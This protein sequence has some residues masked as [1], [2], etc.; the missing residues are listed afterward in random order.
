MNGKVTES[1]IITGMSIGLKGTKLLSIDAIDR[2][3]LMA[4]KTIGKRLK[5]MH[6]IFVWNLI[7]TNGWVY[8]TKIIKQMNIMLMMKRICIVT[9]VII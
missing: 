1:R 3:F 2:S 7:L 8:L 4:M 6:Y 5:N 9:N